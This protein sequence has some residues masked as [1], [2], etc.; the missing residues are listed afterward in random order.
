MRGRPIVQL[1]LLGLVATAIGIAVA[2]LIDWF[3]EQAS[4]EA[5]AVDTL[6]DVLLIVSAPI[7]VLVMAVAIYSVVKFRARPGD[8]RDGAPIHGNARLEVVWVTIPTLIVTGLMI[9]TLFVMDDVESPQPEAMVVD[10]RAEQFAWSFAYPSEDGGPPVQTTDLMVPVG[11]QVEFRIETED[12][13]HSFFVPAFRIKQD[14]VPGRTTVTRATPL[15]EGA[16]DIVC[17]EL[18]GIGHSTMRQTVTV[19]PEEEFDAW[20]TD[21]Q[22]ALA[23]EEDVAPADD[24]SPSG[25]AAQEPPEEEAGPAEGGGSES[26]AGGGG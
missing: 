21:Q 2:L 4:A 10:V 24:Q 25:V 16:Y 20:L 19:M 11:R 15:E 6:Y 17:T 22:E 1:V 23:G 12:V 8:T 26:E 14:T 9:Y 3:P 18:C 5:S 13:L 7:F